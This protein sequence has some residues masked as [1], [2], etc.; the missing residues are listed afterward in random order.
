MT[1]TNLTPEVR[2]R[3]SGF[4]LIE[5]LVVIAIIAIL[6]AMLLPALARSKE[7]AKRIGCVNNLK[8]IGLGSMMY[9]ADFGGNLTAP[10]YNKGLGYVISSTWWAVTDRHGADDDVN[11]LY[12]EYVKAVGSFICP[13]TRNTINATFLPSAN[14]P[15][16]RYI[17]D[18]CNNADNPQK[19]GTSYEV[20]GNFSVSPT[21]AVNGWPNGV[22][23][24]KTEARVLTRTLESYTGH[25]ADKPGPSG[26]FIFADGDDTGANGT[27]NPN[28]NWPDPGNNH[29]NAGASITFCDGHAAFILRKN[30]IDVWNLGNDS[31]RTPPP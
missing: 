3:A 15:S 6:A 10:S 5:L 7:K 2:T 25:I 21:E 30:F 8:Q 14:W 12:P 24:K 4:T 13:S 23:S 29:G 16:G 11:W 18:L 1:K 17:D 19:N 31:N 20:F 22:A 9:A 26:Y 28:N 27:S